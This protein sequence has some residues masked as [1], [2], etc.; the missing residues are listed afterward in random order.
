[1]PVHSA[2]HNFRRCHTISGRFVIRE[3]QLSR[4]SLQSE[5]FTILYSQ[6]FSIFILLSVCKHE[7]KK[8][9]FIKKKRRNY[10]KLFQVFRQTYCRCCFR[11]NKRFY[12]DQP[13][14]Q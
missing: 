2:L 8:T 3:L 14:C 9:T 1:W 12:G 10:R 6:E 4:I 5:K 11:K 7:R 13:D